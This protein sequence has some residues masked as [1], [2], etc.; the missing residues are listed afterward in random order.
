MQI[1]KNKHCNL[2]VILKLGLKKKQENK[3][4]NIRVTPQMK[5]L[6]ILKN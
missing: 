1:K 4:T 2:T 5:D 3:G 6:E